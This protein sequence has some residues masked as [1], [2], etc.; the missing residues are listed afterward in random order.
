MVRYI[1]FLSAFTLVLTSFTSFKNRA[2]WVIA[3]N[4]SLTI[5]GST[6]INKFSCAILSYPKTDTITINDL[7]DLVHL[8]GNLTLNVKNFECNNIMM[9]HQFR[10]TLK[11]EEFP[12]LNINF[13]SL[14]EFPNA[15]SKLKQVKGLVAIKIAG[16]TK[17][18]EICYQ[19]ESQKNNLV[20]TGIQQVNF[21]DFK[22]I[23]PHRVGKMVRAK[24][25]L[26]VIFE[27]RM[28]VVD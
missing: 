8:S 17:K 3:Q 22:L 13:L 28:K 9:T 10:K 14:K 27:L 20:L 18:Y 19:L 26:N 4:S 2:K 6:N 25:Q 15:N 7:N 12:L 5:N 1:L 11:S 21:S 24:D 16:V 23:P